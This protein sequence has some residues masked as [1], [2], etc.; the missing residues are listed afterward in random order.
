MPPLR[1][2]QGFRWVALFLGFGSLTPGYLMPPSGLRSR[3]WNGSSLRCGYRP[4][5]SLRRRS[6]RAAPNSFS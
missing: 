5:V 3:W 2:Y 1:G 6:K 4:L